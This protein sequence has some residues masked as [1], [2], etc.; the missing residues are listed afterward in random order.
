MVFL[1]W[2]WS[3][4]G[5]DKDKAEKEP[6][7]EQ[8][9]L[10]GCAGGVDIEIFAGYG[11]KAVRDGGEAGQHNEDGYGGSLEGSQAQKDLSAKWNPT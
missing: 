7:K 5:A 8:D 3:A 6:D 1:L 11:V 10:N 2:G 4:H 9:M